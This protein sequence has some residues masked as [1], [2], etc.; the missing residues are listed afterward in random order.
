MKTKKEL[1]IPKSKKTIL[2]ID[3]EEDIRALV[4]I[5]LEMSGYN[6][7]EAGTGQQGIKI[8]REK[9]PD[10]ILL[11]I[12]MPTVNGYQVCWYIKTVEKIHV[13]IIMLTALSEP[14]DVKQAEELGADDYIMK[15]YHSSELLEK[16]KRL[17][18][19]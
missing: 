5:R 7:I 9:R 10:L 12:M 17:L 4:R 15:P 6:V 13:P 1:K 8:A 19:E 3:D 2:I 11:D 18:K 16:I 14:R